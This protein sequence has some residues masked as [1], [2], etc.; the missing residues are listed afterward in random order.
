MNEKL[1]KP[2]AY[3][4]KGTWTTE[5]NDTYLYYSCSV[6]SDFNLF[7]AEMWNESELTAMRRNLEIGI[8]LYRIFRRKKYNR[9]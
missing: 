1:F 6:F 7:V 3:F 8:L 9:L 5:P 4:V 2:R